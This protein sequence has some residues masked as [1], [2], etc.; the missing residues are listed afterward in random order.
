MNRSKGDICDSKIITENMQFEYK[1][2]IM[3]HW[4]LDKV[5]PNRKQCLTTMY[6][7]DFSIA[8]HNNENTTEILMKLA[9][10]VMHVEDVKSYDAQSLIGEVGGTLGLTLGLSAKSAVDVLMFFVEKAKLMLKSMK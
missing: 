5:C 10:P 3:E 6:S 2:D 4:E 1:N 9:T 8:K 7:L